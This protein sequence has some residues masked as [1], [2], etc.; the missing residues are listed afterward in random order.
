[1]PQLR[2]IA[3]NAA[4]YINVI[5]WMVICAPIL[6]GPRKWSIAAMKGWAKS[7]MWLTRLTAGIKWEIRGLEHLPRNADGTMSGCI[8]ACKHQ[9]TWETFGLLPYLDDPAY[10]LKQELMRI[11]LFG[12]YCSRAD[13][14]PV[15]RAK[16]AQAL[17]TMTK[18]AKKAVDANRQLIIFPEGTRKAIGA[19]TDYKSGTAHMYKQLAVPM[20]PAGLNSGLFW[21]RRQGKRYPG[22]LVISL[23]PAIPAGE[24]TKKV[25]A[26]LETIIEAE[27]EKLIAEARNDNPQLP[28]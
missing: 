23:L 2:S 13:M 11:P 4:F 14:I 3:A 19:D 22:T 25:R 18:A 28:T 9:S 12:W 15:E 26:E 17:R 27:T 21:P 1:M 20:V 7:T 16:S 10:I 6:L 8:I 5:L 24:D